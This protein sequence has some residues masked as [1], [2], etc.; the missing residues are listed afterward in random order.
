MDG[1]NNFFLANKAIQKTS[2][3]MLR[4][5][6]AFSEKPPRLPAAAVRL[7][8]GEQERVVRHRHPGPVLEP[9]QPRHRAG[10]RDRDQPHAGAEPALRPVQHQVV[11]VPRGRA[12]TIW[13]ASAFP[14]RC[15]PSPTSRQAPIPRLQVGAFTAISNWEN[16]DGVNSSLTHTFSGNLTRL[17]GRHAM[18]FGAE[19]R[20][21]RS[22]NDRHPAAI[23]PDFSFG[24]TYTRGPLDNSTAS[25][26][27]QD[28]ASMLM[29]IPAGSMDRSASSALQD[30]FFGLYFQ[31]D[32]KLTSTADAEYRAALGVRESGNRALRPVRRGLRRHAVESH[33]GAGARPIT[34][35]AP[36][37]NCRLPTSACWAAS[38][39]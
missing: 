16:G 36:Y 32:L 18:K 34:P 19:Y 30:N 9:P 22:F 26:I 28:L 12:A 11:G 29:G 23:V 14:P 35:R 33:R 27:G 4:L 17:Q 10:R 24:T 31:D 6:H 7:L 21:E 2:Q 1:R 5:D 37:R 3:Q 25:T 13:P 15:S 20:L 39:G 38:P 8:E